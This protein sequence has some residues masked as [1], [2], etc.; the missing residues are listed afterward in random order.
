M[1]VLISKGCAKLSHKSK[2]PASLLRR[3]CGAYPL[4]L[5]LV[6]MV[7]WW[8]KLCGRSGALMNVPAQ[9]EAAEDL[10]DVK[11]VVIVSFV[12]MTIT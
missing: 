5:L 7:S 8:L 10:R 9:R 6:G 4:I 3:F 12:R 2:T 11:K 1:D